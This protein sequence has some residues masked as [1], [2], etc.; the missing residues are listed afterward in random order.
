[1]PQ[2]AGDDALLVRRNRADPHLHEVEGEEDPADARPSF[3][4]AGRPNG[5]ANGTA[6]RRNVEPVAGESATRFA[7]VSAIVVLS[8]PGASAGGVSPSR[9]RT[10]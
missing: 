3:G 6:P 7:V 1:M 2:R 4:S 9:T 10:G 8:W 5:S